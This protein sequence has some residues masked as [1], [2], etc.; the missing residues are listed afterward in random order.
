MATDFKYASQSDLNRYVG[1]IVADADSKRQIYGFVELFTH[2]G[3]T[4]YEAFDSGFVSVLFQEGEDLTPYQKTESYTDSTANTDEA[5]DIIETAIDVTDTSVFGYGDIIKID[6]EKMLITN[7]AGSSLHVKRGFLGTHTATHNTG[8]DIHIGVEWS[9]AKQWLSNAG[10]DSV[11]LYEANSTDPN[12]LVM[13]TGLDNS[14]Y[15]DQMLVDASMELNNLLDARF[16]TP[17]LKVAQ[18]DENTATLSQAKEYDAIIIKTTCYLTASNALRAIGETEQADYYYNLVTNAEKTGMVD[19][20]NLGEFKL[21]YE[22][23]SHDSKGK[24]NQKSV[25]GSMDIVEKAGEYVGEAYDLIRITCTTGGAYGV[26][27]VK[28]EY[29]GNDKLFVQESQPEVVTGALQSLAGLGGLYVRFQG[30]S[31][32]QD[33]YWEIEVYSGERKISNAQTGAIDLTRKGYSI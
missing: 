3:F 16:P 21:S 20:L 10:C 5:V 27:H 30:A 9:E 19:R 4:L 2:G 8:V 22:V 18:T 14:T 12:D 24:V 7:I 32:T 15:Y 31:M 1:D 33:D 28:C 29:Y 26:A 23:D 6:D 11:L 13:E 17:L 25:S